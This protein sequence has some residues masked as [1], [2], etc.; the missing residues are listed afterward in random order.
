ME[1][2]SFRRADRAHPFRREQKQQNRRIPGE[3]EAD[4]LAKRIHSQ[5]KVAR[6]ARVS[7]RLRAID[8]VLELSKA[9][10]VLRPSSL[11]GTA[12]EYAGIN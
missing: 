11:A 9:D 6:A 2:F 1:F 4:V 12:T 5:V 3:S 8:P 7:L 10:D